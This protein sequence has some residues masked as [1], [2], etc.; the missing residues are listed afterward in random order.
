MLTA[1]TAEPTDRLPALQAGDGDRL[2]NTHVSPWLGPLAAQ[3]RGGTPVVFLMDDDLLDPAA[4]AE[5]PRAYRRSL[6]QRI[7]HLR[8]RLPE[9]V[10][11]YARRGKPRV[12]TVA[13]TPQ[14]VWYPR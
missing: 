9:L 3:R 10:P 8:R 1:E 5:L 4:Q 12:C 7:T 13:S 14:T 2:V 11:Q 6:W